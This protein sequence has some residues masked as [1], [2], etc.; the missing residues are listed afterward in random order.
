MT[1]ENNENQ[2]SAS[3]G[4]NLLP[5]I[6]GILV[7][8]GLLGAG[9]YFLGMQTPEENNESDEMADSL[10][11]EGDG[12]VA[13]VDGVEIGRE[14]YRRGVEQLVATYA[15]QGITIP[16]EEAEAVK[17]QVVNN[18]INRQ[19]V[20]AA[21]TEAGVQATDEEIEVEFQNVIAN[22]SDAEGLNT[23]LTEA[24]ITE[25]EL[26]ADIEES[27]IINNYL[28]T[29][30]DTESLTVTDEEVAA[31]Y[32]SAKQEADSTEVPP[33]EEVS[34]LIRDQLITE[35]QQQALEVEL[36]RLRAKASI[37]VLI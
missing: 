37:E 1:E 5:A 29:R 20:L 16:D 10:D 35:K 9:Y 21:A 15:T 27:V 25:E 32:E 7:V 33:L 2:T 18:L 31:Y 3:K 11:L 8:L 19:L 14:E 4:N 36:E 12:P 6:I 23:A 28:S 26:R 30:V 34:E 17:E 13:R 22:F 24:G